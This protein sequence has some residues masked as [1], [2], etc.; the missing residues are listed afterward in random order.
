MKKPE[1]S[2]SAASN[3]SFS[4]LP[5][6]LEHYSPRTLRFDVKTRGALPIA[7]ACSYARQAALGLQHAH[8][9]GMVHRD[10][11]PGN[12]LVAAD[13]KGQ[14]SARNVVKILDMGLA[15]SPHGNSDGSDAS[16]DL[17]QTGTVIGTPDYMSPEQAKNSSG[18][19]HRSD[20]YSLGCTFY[21]LLTAA[22]PF[23]NGSPVEKLLQHQMDAP[24]PVQQLRADIPPELATIVHC[25][26][27][28]RPDDRFQSAG[29]VAKALGPW[30][31]G[32]SNSAMLPGPP[33]S[34]EAVDPLSGIFESSHPFDFGDESE[35]VTP[36]P[37]H[38]VT[39]TRRLPTVSRTANNQRTLPWAIGLAFLFLVFLFVGAVAANIFLGGRKKSDDTAP[40]PR[41]EPART[42]PAKS[43]PKIKPDPPPAKDLEAAE[44]F[45]PDDTSVAALFDLKQWQSSAVVRSLVVAPVSDQLAGF[46]KATGIDLLA[47][48]E[49]V[50][51]GAAADDEAVV[52]LQGRSLVTPRLVEGVK[53]MPGVRFEPAWEGGPE[54]TVLGDDKP[55]KVFAVASETSVVLSPHRRRVIEALEKRD[56]GRRTRLADQTIARGLEYAY[57]RPFAAFVTLGLRQDWAKSIP[58]ATKLN[59]AAAGIV[60]DDRGMSFH[61]LADET[62][63]GKAIELQRAF[64]RLLADKGKA[65]VPA[66]LRLDRI[67]SLLLDAEP[68]RLPPPR[69]RLTHTQ[70]LVPARRLEEW[71][72]PFIP[73][74]DE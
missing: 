68:V 22:I 31:G 21:H 36:P 11:K 46:R 47:A 39:A 61:T 42:E 38:R 2:Q 26:L 3:S 73:K 57:A 65:T 15:R 41:S 54:L 67:A 12:L 34:A 27:A 24:R 5:S 28:K 64:G 37:A 74:G 49:R 14:Y 8:D 23:P 62:E 16:T 32:T 19:D 60:F 66:D 51:V 33:L 40:P 9:H 50:V 6:A 30:T 1:G 17:T 18:V 25:L 43:P 56:G 44:K 10:I 20:L 59:F 69:L 70:H 63:P 13:N 4:I 55:E 45:L 48:A 52:I 35:F 58:G 53:A 71:F 29:A 72:A 7:M